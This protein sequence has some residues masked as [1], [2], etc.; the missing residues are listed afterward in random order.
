MRW[1]VALFVLLLF[2]GLTALFAAAAWA[3]RRDFNERFE[4][5]GARLRQQAEAIV[6][7][8]PHDS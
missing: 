1:I 5:I 6:R 8:L 4:R 2:V 7:N 3:I